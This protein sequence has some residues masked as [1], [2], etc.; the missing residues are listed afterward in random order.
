MAIYTTTIGDRYDPVE[1]GIPVSRDGFLHVMHYGWSPKMIAGDTLRVDLRVPISEFWI[2]QFAE[3]QTDTPFAEFLIERRR[4]RR[5]NPVVPDQWSGDGTYSDVR[6]VHRLAIATNLMVAVRAGGE[7]G[8]DRPGSWSELLDAAFVERDRI[9][10]AAINGGAGVAMNTTLALE[11]IRFGLK[12][13]RGE[14][15]APQILEAP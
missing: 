15:R 12:T 10:F 5:L 14:S 9:R 4:H 1:T 7:L 11:V 13:S 3:L 8:P 2:M 6:L